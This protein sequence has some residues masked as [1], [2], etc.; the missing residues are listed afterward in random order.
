[1]KMTLRLSDKMDKIIDDVLE[2]GEARNKTQF[3][4]KAIYV[5]SYL[6]K[7]RKSGYEIA[8]IQEDRIEILNSLFDV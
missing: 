7:R 2:T 4:Q 8:G 1:M 5:Y 3:I 6:T